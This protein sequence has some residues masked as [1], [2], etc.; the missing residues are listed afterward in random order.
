MWRR[1]TALLAVSLLAAAAQTD[2]SSQDKKGRFLDKNTYNNPAL[3]MT[4]KLPGAWEFVT[5]QLKK[6]M[7]VEE[8]KAVNDPSCTGPLCRSVINVSLIT[9]AEPV[10]T[11]SIFLLAYKLEP[12]YLD[13]KRYPLRMFAQSMLTGSVG[14]SGWTPEGEMAPIQI[15][16]KPAYR[17][18]VQQPSSKGCGY[19][20]ESNGYVFMIIGVA[21]RLIPEKFAQIREVLEKMKLGS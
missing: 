17:L 19:V 13:R 8:E 20:A 7:G 3:G 16:G 5:E 2:Q 15:D 9:K 18:L 11:A 10:A 12:Q 6:D 1:F 14:G 4:L 21:P